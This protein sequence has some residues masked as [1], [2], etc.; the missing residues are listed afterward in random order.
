[1]NQLTNIHKYFTILKA[2]NAIRTAAYA[3]V[4]VLS[5]FQVFKAYR[6]I[7]K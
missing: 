5:I 6:A 4:A 2:A 3:L 1:M 7:M